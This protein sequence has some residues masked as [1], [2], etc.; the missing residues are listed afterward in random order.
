MRRVAKAE[1]STFFVFSGAVNQRR[2]TSRQGGAKRTRPDWERGCVGLDSILLLILFGLVVCFLLPV[3]SA[4]ATTQFNAY[5]QVEATGVFELHLKSFTNDH[6]LNAD[7]NCCN[8]IRTG[9][10]CTSQCHTFFHV[11][12]THYQAAISSSASSS[13]SS[14]G[15]SGPGLSSSSDLSSVDSPIRFPIRDFAWP[16]DFSLIIEAWHD[17]TLS[18]PTE[19]SSREL[20]QRLAVQ[21]SASAGRDWYNSNY[22]TTSTS[23]A[24]ASSSG[25]SSTTTQQLLYS[26][27]F[28]CDPTYYG[29]A[30]TVLCRARDD[31]F[32]HYYCDSSNGTKVCLDGWSGEYCDEAICLPGCHPDYGICNRP[33]ECRCRKGWQGTLCNECSPHPD[34]QHGTCDARPYE[35][36]CLEGWGGL[37]CNQES[38]DTGF[39]C[40]C[41]P[42][43]YG[44]ACGEEADFCREATCH[45]GGTCVDHQG[46][47]Q[48]LC[49]QGFSGFHCETDTGGCKADSCRNGGHCVDGECICPSGFFGPTCEDDG[50]DYCALQPCR[51]GGTCQDLTHDF[52]CRCVAGFVGPTCEVNVDDC[53]MRPC[54]N[55]GSCTDLVNDFRCRCAPGWTG[56]DCSVNVNDCQSQPCRHGGVC[57]DRIDDY[58]CTCP[59]GFWGKD[60]EAYEGMATTTSTTPPTPRPP[61]VSPS[62]HNVTTPPLPPLSSS[63]SVTRD[64]DHR[65]SNVSGQA[66]GSRKGEEEK[67]E[68]LFGVCFGVGFP[69]L[70]LIVL[71][72]VLLRWKRRRRSSSS[73]SSDGMDKERQQNYLNNISALNKASTRVEEPRAKSLDDSDCEGGGGGGGGKPQHGWF[74][75]GE[76]SGV[77]GEETGWRRWCW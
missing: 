61:A 53:E 34:C 19:G 42:G 11:C 22:T 26:Y 68:I 31:H 10:R 23:S 5:I 77:C 33:Y 36:N 69:I 55:G 70:L 7:G 25:L 28:V 20:I 64:P 30:C 9:E 15:G 54:A 47:Y 62:F 76:C 48:C 43:F 67:R 75:T 29:A 35:C 74:S 6:G 65:S 21:S 56:K 49:P 57:E 17:T 8:G 52:K 3:A 13:S 46:S 51:N 44:A 18:G 16:G 50:H 24:S 45:N 58:E 12:L 59:E 40:I 32:G 37:L 14:S 73:S 27:R 1:P 39:T 63:S 66:G 60:C 71:A 4:V 38:T 2:V 72:V 41:P